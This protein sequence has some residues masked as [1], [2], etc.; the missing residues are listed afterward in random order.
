MERITCTQT[1]LARDCR[2]LFNISISQQMI[3]KILAKGNITRKKLTIQA[4]EQ[5]DKLERHLEFHSNIINVPQSKLLAMDETSFWIND[6]P[7]YGYSQRGEFAIVQ[8]SRKRSTKITLA[9]CISME[10]KIN[11]S[12]VVAYAIYPKSMTSDKFLHFLNIIGESLPNITSSNDEDNVDYS[13]YMILDNGSFHGPP[14]KL[15]NPAKPTSIVSKIKAKSESICLKLIYL[16]PLSP[17]FNPTEYA[18]SLIKR[19]VRKVC[20]RNQQ[21]LVIAIESTIQKLD[22]IHISNT[23][24]HCIKESTIE[25]NQILSLVNDQAQTDII[26]Q[27]KS[28]DDFE[29][30]WCISHVSTNKHKSFPKIPLA[31]DGKLACSQ[32]VSASCPPNTKMDN[33]CDYCKESFETSTLFRKHKRRCKEKCGFCN[34]F[35]SSPNFTRHQKRDCSENSNSLK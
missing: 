32:N 7:R 16:R 1:E 5:F 3:S 4:I 23:F 30:N 18:F 14:G 22:S 31:N 12:C 27:G 29:G 21:E 34:T 35:I 20:P 8:R 13:H 33:E 2:E 24:K 28:N 9:L 25:Y 17:Q 10:P 6:G 19:A 26:D 11:G 15:V